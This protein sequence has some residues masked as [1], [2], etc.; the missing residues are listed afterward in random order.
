M[1]DRTEL[2]VCFRQWFERSHLSFRRRVLSP[3]LFSVL[4]D[5][6]SDIFGAF[7]DHVL[8]ELAKLEQL[9]VFWVAQPRQYFYAILLLALKVVL[10]VVDDD[11][12]FEV[13]AQKSEIFDVDSI[14]VQAM[15]PIEPVLNI[16]LVL[17]NVIQHKI[18]IVFGSCRENDHFEVLRHIF[19]E[20]DATRS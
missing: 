20:L 11:G 7:T 10:Y 13:S 17:V 2:V 1:F 16:F 6:I 19:Q 9:S 5:I 15:M 14:V 3:L 4:S 12:L 8:Q 18:G